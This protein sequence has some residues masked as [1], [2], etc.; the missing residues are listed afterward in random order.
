MAGGAAG[1]AAAAAE[2]TEFDVVLT[3]GGDNKINVKGTKSLHESLFASLPRCKMKI[4]YVQ[5][6]D[7]SRTYRQNGDCSLFFANRKEVALNENAPD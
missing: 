3:S 4:A 2:K 5:H 7:R 6:S 1:G